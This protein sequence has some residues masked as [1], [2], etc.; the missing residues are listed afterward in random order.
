M[1]E[2]F[3]FASILNPRQETQDKN[4]VSDVPRHPAESSRDRRR[5]PHPFGKPSELLQKIGLRGKEV[6]S[7]LKDRGWEA[8]DPKALQE[9]KLYYIPGGKAKGEVAVQGEDF[10]V[11]EGEL[12]AYI[13]EKGG[14]HYLLPEEGYSTESDFEILDQRPP[15]VHQNEFDARTNN[16]QTIGNSGELLQASSDTPM[17]AS[18]PEQPKRKRRKNLST[19]SGKKAK[20]AKRQVQ[21]PCKRVDGKPA[22][23][24]TECR[25]KEE[26]IPFVIADGCGHLVEFGAYEAALTARGWRAQLLQDIDLHLLRCVAAIARRQRAL[27]VTSGEQNFSLFFLPSEGNCTPHEGVHREL[28]VVSSGITASQN[29]LSSMVAAIIG[30]AERTQSP[31]RVECA[32]RIGIPGFVSTGCGNLMLMRDIDRHLLLIVAAVRQYL[33]ARNTSNYSDGDI[34][35]SDLRALQLNIEKMNAEL[36]ELLTIINILADRNL[37]N[38]DTLT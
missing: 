16:A 10:F 20:P 8:C 18:D 36:T 6:V 19:A 22:A 1:T 38:T 31:E 15:P 9:H 27:E 25:V 33:R 12:Y 30:Q 11:G 3:S 28:K 13:L 26:K 32:A 14:L 24:A 29:D 34:K 4:V 23:S 7:I 21:K 35:R 5:N 17:S 2:S 37:N